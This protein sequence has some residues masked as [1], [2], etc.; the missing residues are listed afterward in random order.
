MNAKAYVKPI[1][2]AAKY[3]HCAVNGVL[4]AE[5]TKNK[6]GKVVKL[7]DAV[8]LFHSSLTLAPMMEIA[9]TQVIE[10]YRGSRDG[11]WKDKIML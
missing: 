3:P 8:P 6:D 7:V 2:H 10:D 11:I 5:L 4:L 9:L 1:L